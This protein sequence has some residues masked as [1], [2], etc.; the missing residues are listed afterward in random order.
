MGSLRFIVFAS[1]GYPEINERISEFRLTAL[2]Q[3][4]HICE[5]CGQPGELVTNHRIATMCIE[6]AKQAET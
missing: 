2:N 1:D 6:H 5:Q 4:L 3:S